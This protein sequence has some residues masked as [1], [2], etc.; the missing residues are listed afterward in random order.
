[1]K[2]RAG[3]HLGYQCQQDTPML[4]VVNIHLSRRA[5][6]LT[7]QI[8]SFDRP[9][10]AWS[11]IDGLGNACNRRRDDCW[12]RTPTPPAQLLQWAMKARRSSVANTPDCSG[13][14]RNAMTLHCAK[15]SD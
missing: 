11:Y 15:T 4:L 12:P 7:D 8:L 6:L 10:E 1:M 9:T 14:H 5:D 13:Y 3:F 2:I